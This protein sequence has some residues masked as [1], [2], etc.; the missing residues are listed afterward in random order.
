MNK[1]TLTRM[2]TLEG[3]KGDWEGFDCEV[4]CW[5]PSGRSVLYISMIKDAMMEENK[6]FYR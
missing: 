6:L 5:L 4:V 3:W 2:A 1:M